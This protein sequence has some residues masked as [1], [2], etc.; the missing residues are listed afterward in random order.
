[1]NLGIGGTFAGV[2]VTTAGIQW[3]EDITHILY[4][5]P[6]LLKQTS[7][8]IETARSKENQDAKVINCYVRDDEL[9]VGTRTPNIRFTLLRSPFASREGIE[10]WRQKWAD[11][12]SERTR[13]F[14]SR[15]FIFNDRLRTRTVIYRSESEIPVNEGFRLA[16]GESNLMFA[17]HPRFLQLLTKEMSVSW[18]MQ[19]LFDAK[20]L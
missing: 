9:F 3:Q 13:E 18:H 12:L 5:S 17:F 7:R 20:N 14:R 16:A 19:Y 4:S 11:A 2:A 15:Y 8:D 1:M 10:P 6:V